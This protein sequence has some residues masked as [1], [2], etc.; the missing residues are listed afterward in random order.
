MTLGK[1]GFCCSWISPT[2][3]QA[4]EALLNT[5]T[6]TITSLSKMTKGN[7]MARLL[8]MVD[9]NLQTLERMITHVSMM[10]DE[11]KMIRFGSDILPAYTHEVAQWVYREP[12]MREIMETGF[13]RV[14][15]IA[16]DNNIRIT[17]HPGQYCVLNSVNEATYIRAVAEFE[18]HVDMMRMMGLATGWHPL[19][20]GINIHTGSRA[21]GI[22]GLINGIN[23]LSDDAKNLITIENDELSFG[24]TDLEYVA[25]YA[26]IVLDIHHEWIFSKGHYIQPDDPRIDYILESWR[27]VRPVGHY[28]V[29]RED[30]LVGHDPDVL[31]DF[32]ALRA[33]GFSLRDLRAHSDM[34][35]SNAANE[36]ALSHLSWMDLEVEAKF[37]NLARDQLHNSRK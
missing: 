17:F 31:P 11:K 7:A 27:G 37:K 4:A 15:Q 26:A 20:C 34:C 1:L 25:N 2:G 33:Q 10:P 32:Q 6:T 28:A 14:G 13:A 36:W 5:K 35:W 12:A 22:I 19:G 16:K 21:G 24:L 23:G 18:Y 8:N 29:S 9:A 30:V 3:D